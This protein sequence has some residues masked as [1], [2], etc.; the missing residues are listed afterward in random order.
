LKNVLC[1]SSYKYGPQKQKELEQYNESRIGVAVH[2]A[3]EMALDGTPLRQAFQ[4]A[5]DKHE[6]TSD[7][8]EQLESF[9]EQVQRFVKK[10]DAFK[11][12]HR[13]HPANVMIERK[14]GMRSNFN[15]CSFFEKG[16]TCIECRNGP[17]QHDTSGKC[18]FGPGTSLKTL[19]VFFR[20]VVDY[21]ILTE[22][23]DLIIIDH[24][25]GKEGDI[26]KYSAQFKSYCLMA[27]AHIPDLRGIQTAVNFVMTD[28]TVWNPYVK[29]EVIR[30]EYRPWMVEY[31]TKSCEK[32]LSP[33][34]PTTGWWCNWCGYRS[35]C[36]A[37]TE[38]NNRVNK[39]A[40]Q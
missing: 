37:M 3:L 4:M 30:D 8:L 9:F 11:T 32:L 33:P 19:P 38:K 22:K 20:G 21:A 17:S 25:S 35:I 7:E 1:S 15:A 40:G 14:W 29:A 36:P 5:G 28:H 6:L 10:M 13:V 23:K 31:L 24:K 39:E 26:A 16:E 2:M 34:A 12:K 27:H 18:L